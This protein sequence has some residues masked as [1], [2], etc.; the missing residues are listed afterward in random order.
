M[1]PGMNDLARQGALTNLAAKFSQWLNLTAVATVVA[2]AL[3]LVNFYYSFFY[4]SNDVSV[5]VT[6]VIYD[7]NT[8]QLYMTVALANGGNRDAALL[9]VEPVLWR[10]GAEPDARWQALEQPI[11]ANIPLISPATPL[12]IKAGAV[13]VTASS[14]LLDATAAEA[15]RDT[16]RGGIY[17]GVRVG[18]VDAE[19]HRFLVAHPVARLVTDDS[20]RT[21][22]GEAVIS[23][24]FPA[25]SARSTEPPGR[26]PDQAEAGPYVWSHERYTY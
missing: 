5:T 23:G 3:S 1:R 12:V 24:S 10:A 2:L 17:L 9:R 4:V 15:Q 21:L 18:M 19:G 11:A 14:T 26:S 22:R 8:A 16:A 13:A 6:E 25:F 20:G 7:P